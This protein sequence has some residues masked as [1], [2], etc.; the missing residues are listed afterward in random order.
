MDRLPAAYP[1]PGSMDELKWV[2]QEDSLGR[3]QQ[4]QYGMIIPGWRPARMLVHLPAHL[5]LHGSISFYIQCP[6]VAC[7]VGVSF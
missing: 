5:M 2:M 3:V 1:A 7:A 4:H 6:G